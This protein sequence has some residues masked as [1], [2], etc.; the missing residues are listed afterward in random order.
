M[1][2]SSL[3]FFTAFYTHPQDFASGIIKALQYWLAQQ[4]V[5]RGNQPIWYYFMQVPLYELIVAAFALPALWRLTRRGSLTDRFLCFWFVAAV[6]LYSL[7][8]ER[9]PWLVL[10]LSLP[11]I[12]LVARF[13]GQ[14]FSEPHGLR[15]HRIALVLCLLISVYALHT[16]LPLTF[17]HGD[18][19]RDLLVYVQTSPDVPYVTAQ[20]EQMSRRLTGTT[21]IVGIIDNEDSWP[22]AWYLRDYTKVG[23]TSNIGDP[24]RRRLSS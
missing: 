13:L 24:G 21:D 3:S 12:L 23:Y 5:S 11:G 17:A 7:A 9:M 2:S 22:F 10:H 20:I 18:T 1:C 15:R 16:G 8:G 6:L 4:E 19:P 14:Q